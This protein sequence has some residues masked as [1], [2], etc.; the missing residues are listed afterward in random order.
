M[1]NKYY[2]VCF[3]YKNGLITKIPYEKKSDAEECARTY[4]EDFEHLR[5]WIE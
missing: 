5:V 2:Y 4:K 1:K 3:E